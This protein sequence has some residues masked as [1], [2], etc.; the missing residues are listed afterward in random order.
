MALNLE[1][2]P[3]KQ[4][5]KLELNQYLGLASGFVLALMMLISGVYI[6]LSCLSMLA[7][8]AVLY[9]IPHMMKVKDIKVMIAHGAVF[10]VAALLVG[11]LYTSPSYVDQHDSFR[12][13][14]GFSNCSYTVTAEGY[15][16]QVSYSDSTPGHEPR[17]QLMIVEKIGYYSIYGIRDG[18]NVISPDS[19]A[20]NTATFKV[21]VDD[22]LYAI[23]FFME[24]TANPGPVV[25]GTQSVSFFLRDKTSD[26][27]M[28]SVIWTGTLYFL[29]MCMMMYF[30]ILFFSHAIRNSAIKSRRRMEAQGRLYPVG[31]GRCKQC[32]AIVLPGEVTCRKCGTYIDVPE[33]MKPQKKDFFTCFECGAEVEG[34]MNECPKC[35]AEF[36]DGVEV[37]VERVDGTVE[38]IEVTECQDCGEEIPSAAG[39]CPKCGK[40]TKK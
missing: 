35:G 4:R 25:E 36:D 20:G 28:T 3:G 21:N 14:G 18:T 26:S 24:D 11:G 29:G 15:D 27:V 37:E 2:V 23:F 1:E 31:Y 33:E 12:D 40:E 9:L 39:S 6:H 22:R 8:G 38:T 13:S 5:Q 19:M 10:M 34:S 16:I 7:I 30:M 17:I 32:N